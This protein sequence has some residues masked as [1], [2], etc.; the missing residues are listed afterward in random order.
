M[1][2]LE[3]ARQSLVITSDLGSVGGA[4][5]GLSRAVER[6]TLV[7]L[8]HGVYLDAALWAPL[9]NAD[10][11]RLLATIA[12]RLS[13]PGLVFS[14]Q[15]A[16]ALI[17]LPVLGRWPDRAHVVQDCAAGGRSTSVLIRHTV[18]LQGVPCQAIGQL[19]ATS[20][21][22]TVIDLAATLPY[23]VAVVAT[24]AALHLDRY[25][26]E[27]VTTR[28]DVQA[29]L[30]QM[31][32]FRGLKRVLA[33]LDAST[34]LSD[35]VAESLCRIIIDELGFPAPELQHEFRDTGGLIGYAD[36]TWLS[37]RVI[38]EFDGKNK[39]LDP[40]LRH[41]LSADEVVVLEKLRE[42]RLR[43]L[44]FRVVRVGWRH[45][46]DPTGLFRMLT[47]AGLTPVRP[48]RVIRRDWL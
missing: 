32:P 29:L 33:V 43:A 9:D 15:T 25:T 35:S 24:D 5:S 7:R 44:G 13:G 42:D 34:E 2:P 1:T 48:T 21:A 31:A 47:D 6:G 39:Y 17:G 8:K 41:G 28:A 14:H 37:A 12:E 20:P 3:L 46:V 4:G 27:C 23:D 18:G 38:L 26:R 10:R 11:H 19:T 22:R 30:E 40:A 16:A 45:L 36:F